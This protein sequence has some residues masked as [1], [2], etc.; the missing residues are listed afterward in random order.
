MVLAT[1]M[2]VMGCAANES[3]VA[4]VIRPISLVVATLDSG[5]C[6]LVLRAWGDT[7]LCPVCGDARRG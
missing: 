3:N 4:L 5:V 7:A 1:K 6:V 2:Q